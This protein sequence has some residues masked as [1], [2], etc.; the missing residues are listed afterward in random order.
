M[1]EDSKVTAGINLYVNLNHFD[2]EEKRIIRKLSSDWYISN[3]GGIIELGATSSYKYFLLKPT[4][5]Y[6]ELFNIEREIVAVF[7]N[8]SDFEP[9]TLDAFDSAINKHQELRIERVCSV[10]ISK[11]KNIETRIRNLL[12]SDA[13][14]QI[15]VPFS[16]ED[17]LK[18]SDS[19]FIRNR[20]R[21]HFYTRDLFAFQTALKKDLYFFGRRDLVHNL[22]SRHRSNENAGLFGLRK[23]GKTS[24]IFGITRLIDIQGGMSIFIDCE[25]PSFH[26]KRWFSALYYIIDQLRS[27]NNISIKISDKSKYSEEE[28]ASVFE[29]ELVKI[30]NQTKKKSFLLI[31][32][33]I[34]HITPGISA[35]EHWKSGSDF[36]FFWQTLRS[37]FQKHNQLFTYLIAGTNPRCVEIDRINSIDNP[38]FCQVPYEYIPSFNLSQTTEM[39]RKLSKI[40]GLK[41]D[42]T[43]YGNLT[44]DFGGHPFLIR[45]V[46]SIIN[47]QVLN[48]QRPVRIDKSIYQN[49]VNIFNEKYSK[50]IEMILSVLKEYYNDEF[51]MLKF[52]ALGDIKTF[53]DLA[54]LS[55][56]YTNHLLGYG[57]LD[58]NFNNFTFKIESIKLFLTESNKYKKINLSNEEKLSEM[59]ERINKAEIQLRKL[60][61]QVLRSLL[62]EENAKQKVLAKHDSRKKARYNSLSYK[63]L[64][65]PNKHEIYLDDLRELMRTNWENGFRNIFS[66]DVEKFNSKMV[67]LNSIGRSYAHSK[68]VSDSDMQMFRGT[69][70]WLEEKI[71]EYFA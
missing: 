68:K 34:E 62:G 69:M 35:S 65:D 70:S 45:N 15:I 53:D 6:Q 30:Y 43:I 57:I 66:E 7:S 25:S 40:M 60:V 33:E 28:A 11:D 63:E 13:E 38:I 59:E 61:S 5:L 50:Y 31:F 64:F 48:E 71:N 49:A 41:F 12:K 26:Q 9:R 42:D 21:E 3:G 23:T 1:G 47:E 44:E 14:Y 36:V 51:E 46:C 67:I 8:Y 52:L 54:N 4:P 29:K 18:N 2:E 27:Q 24:I 32:D 55:K 19:F 10:L 16:F 37:I 58:K 20:F 17:I 39:V 56:D 22:F